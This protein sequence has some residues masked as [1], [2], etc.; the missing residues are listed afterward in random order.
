MRRVRGRDGF[1]L[2]ATLGVLA[3]LASLAGGAALLTRGAH[4]GVRTASEVLRLDAL[5]RAGIDL[6]AYQLLGLRLPP[7]R[8]AGEIR[9]DDGTVRIAASDETGRIDLN[10]SDPA[11]LAAAARAAGLRSLPPAAF[12]AAAVAWRTR[13]EPPSG[14]GPPARVGDGPAAAPKR[15]GFRTVDDLR[16]LP[17]LSADEI[18]GLSDL[19]TVH[20]PS[21]R[22]N[23][24]AAPD[25]VLLAL[26]GATPR[27][28]EEA[29]ALRRLP[30]AQAADQVARIFSG[31]SS[32]VTAKP[33]GA[34]RLRVEA[35]RGPA[36][37]RAVTV[38]LIGSP[39]DEA[40]YFL[41]EW[42]D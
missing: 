22:V 10:W 4:D 2:I 1:I 11:L 38:V 8:I 41:T 36:S 13:N 15:E 35:R 32:F 3:L 6:A 31:S 25:A 9:L 7:D 40:P 29:A 34:F 14:A 16:W 21:G 19:L 17:G 39:P 5:V 18:A 33:G 20:N 42:R 23:V 27:M 37:M 24:L 26:P 28:V 30:P 12:A